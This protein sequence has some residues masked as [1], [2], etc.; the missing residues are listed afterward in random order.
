[1]RASQ[2]EE[3][4]ALLREPLRVELGAASAC[5]PGRR[6]RVDATLTVNPVSDQ[7]M[8]RSREMIAPTPGERG[9]ASSRSLFGSVARIFFNVSADP[10]VR[11]LRGLSAYAPVRDERGAP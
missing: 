3:V 5:Q 10:G 7:V 2:L 6:Y 4:V 8:Q 11:E 1:V 9:G